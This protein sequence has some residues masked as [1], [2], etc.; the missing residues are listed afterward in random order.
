MKAELTDL[1][2]IGTVVGKALE[3]L[4]SGSGMILVLIGLH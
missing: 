2:Q 1:S 3:P 4:Q